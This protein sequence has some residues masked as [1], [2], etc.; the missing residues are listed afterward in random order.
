MAVVLG[1]WV[2]GIEARLVFLQ[3]FRHADLVARAERQQ[4]RTRSSPAKR[5][6]IL[7]R[8]GRVL[9]TS[10]D[11]DTIF[12]V[13]S[14]IDDVKATVAK[15]CDA[16][17]D[18]SGKERQALTEKLGK[19]K[20]FAYVRRQIAPDVARRVADL[21]LDGIGF[22]K[23][24]KRFYPNRELAAHLLGYVGV[25][26]SGLSGIESTY[27]SQIRGKVGTI[28]VQ[29]DAQAA[30]VQPL[31]AAA[32]HRFDGRADHR[33]VPAARRRA[34][35]PRRRRPE[36]RRRRHRHHHESA[37]RRDSGDGQRADVQPERLS[38]LRGCRPAQPRGAG[39]L[40]AGIDVQAGDRVGGDRREA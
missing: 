1:L 33:R 7:D 38:R 15:L 9:A 17:G 35:A 5:G 3:V 24:S 26:N 40:R 18:C 19:S 28:M 16:F 12:A 10:V 31:R 6:D 25:D 21:N 29:T 22:V 27:D 14:D 37:H 13:P 11:A 39:S 34:R 20:Q 8:R 23:E 30:R 2:G 32:D 36:P 4:E